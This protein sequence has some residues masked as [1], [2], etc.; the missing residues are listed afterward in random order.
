MAPALEAAATRSGVSPLP[1]SGAL[2]IGCARPR[3]C[4]KPVLM[5]M[6]A[7]GKC[8]VILSE[9]DENTPLPLHRVHEN[10]RSGPGSGLA[11]L[12]RFASFD[13]SLQPGE[14]SRP[15]TVLLAQVG[16]R[17]ES[18]MANPDQRSLLFGFQFPADR[19]FEV[20]GPT[21][22]PGLDQE[23]RRVNL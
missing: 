11:V 14:Q 9:L 6:T 15:A 22:D 18:A 10:A 20:A 1:A 17:G 5:L 13:Q 2:M 23:A 12:D 7:S 19:R 8:S 3:P 21:G 4:I 16:P